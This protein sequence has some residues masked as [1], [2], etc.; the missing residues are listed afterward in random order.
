M[1][2]TIGDMGVNVATLDAASQNL[3]GEATQRISELSSVARLQRDEADAG[4]SDQGPQS[5]SNPASSVTTTG[6]DHEQNSLE[7]LR[8][9]KLEAEVE[10]KFQHLN[11][12]I[13]SSL[14]A[15]NAKQ[16][17]IFE[18]GARLFVHPYC[19]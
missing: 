6:G 2:D 10:S 13:S 5:A 9:Q 3:V 11:D 7:D 8:D 1:Q 14:A 16:T 18:V 15:G 17:A 19:V 12:D 4:A